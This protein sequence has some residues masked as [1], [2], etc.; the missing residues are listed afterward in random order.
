MGVYAI[1]TSNPPSPSLVSPIQILLV[2]KMTEVTDPKKVDAQHTET[3]TE[4]LTLSARA[5][6]FEAQQH[7][8]T[9]KEAIRANIRPLA[10]CS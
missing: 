5:A 8:L 10:W 7:A 9:R 1:A 3:A 2:A 6:Q 4:V